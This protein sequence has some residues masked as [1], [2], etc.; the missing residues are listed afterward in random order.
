MIELTEEQEVLLEEL[1]NNFRRGI[2]GPEGPTWEE[3][4]EQERGGDEMI[5]INGQK[6]VCEFCGRT[7]CGMIE[8]DTCG[9]CGRTDCGLLLL[10]DVWYRVCPECRIKM[11]KLKGQYVWRG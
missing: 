1:V 9:F 11:L 6:V 10:N 7:D 4:L 3:F 5:D 8:K 2:N